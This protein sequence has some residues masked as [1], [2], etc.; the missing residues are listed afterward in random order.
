M[1]YARH[2]RA[3]SVSPE[4]SEFCLA[5]DPVSVD[6]SSPA[7]DNRLAMTMPDLN[8]DILLDRDFVALNNGSFGVC[9]K[10]VFAEYQRW[11]R[12]LEEQPVE[13]LG[14]RLDGLLAEA[15]APLGAY[16]GTAPDQSGLR[17]QHDLWRQ[18]DRAC[19]PAERQAIEVLA[20]TRI[21]RGRA[22]VDIRL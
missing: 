4:A 8:E 12:T 1:E 22:D 11:Q 20:T 10:P 16:L 13:F 21:W 2:S 18:R 17:A 14:R 3:P 6:V 19:V 9:P 7:L 15:R 5:E